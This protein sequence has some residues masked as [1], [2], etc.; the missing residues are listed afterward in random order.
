MIDLSNVHFVQ[1]PTVQQLTCLW[2]RLGQ[3]KSIAWLKRAV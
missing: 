3:I 1:S 2:A